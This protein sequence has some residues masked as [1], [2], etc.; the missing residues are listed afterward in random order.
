MDVI[1]EKP[2]KQCEKNDKECEDESFDLN[3]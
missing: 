2:E 1:I 3:K